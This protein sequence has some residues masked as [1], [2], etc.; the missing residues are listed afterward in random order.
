MA[1]P[2][3]ADGG[4]LV[5][6]EYEG[7]NGRFIGLGAM[8]TAESSG[9]PSGITGQAASGGCQQVFLDNIDGGSPVPAR[10][11]S[12]ALGWG[13]TGPRPGS[14]DHRGQESTEASL[15]GLKIEAGDRS[16]GTL[17]PL[18]SAERRGRSLIPSPM[19]MRKDQKTEKRSSQPA[20]VASKS[21]LTISTV[22]GVF[23][24]N[25]IQFWVAS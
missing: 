23:F 9:L 6:Q 7:A 17:S 22:P 21:S 15:R 24:I 12:G 10:A 18:R 25:F 16:C 5:V 4:D 13:A 2:R 1:S 14:M 19:K 20:A 3:P 8:T 11:A